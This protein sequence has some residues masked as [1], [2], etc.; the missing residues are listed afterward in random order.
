MAIEVNLRRRWFGLFHLIVSA[1][2]L[3]WGLTLLRPVLRGWL[4]LG[5]WLVCFCFALLALVT[6]W[7]DWRSV[8]RQARAERRALRAGTLHL[9][10]VSQP[11][12]AQTDARSPAR[13]SAPP[14][15]ADPGR[16][17]NR[18]PSDVQPPADPAA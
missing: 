18:P 2:L 10:P 15:G 11:A 6:A 16:V 5:Y 8:Q 14:P 9:R 3:I 13:P 17:S 1:G 4:F 7:L 12:A